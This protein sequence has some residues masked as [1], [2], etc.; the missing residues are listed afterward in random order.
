MRAQSHSC[1]KWNINYDKWKNA[2][3][4]DKE[5]ACILKDPHLFTGAYAGK[6]LQ[7]K[8][9]RIRKVFFVFRSLRS[10]EHR[11]SFTMF[12]RQKI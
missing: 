9:R 2:G 12:L 11:K 7:Q 4:N 1:V 8:A 6:Y 3:R 5:T 10:K